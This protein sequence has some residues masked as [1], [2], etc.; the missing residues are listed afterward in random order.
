MTSH[1]LWL[2]L[3][4]LGCYHGIN[5]A[6][7]WLF[8]VALGLQERSASAVLRAVVPLTLGHLLSVAVIVL[9]TVFAVAQF[10]HAIVQRVAA[11]VLLGFGGYRLIR[12]RHPRWV[13]MQVGFWG[14]TAWG[15][16]MSS[17][18]GAGLMLVPFVTARHAGMQGAM[19]MPGAM[20]AAHAPYA[21]GWLVITVHTLGY[22]VAMTTAAFLVYTKFGVSFLRTAWFNVDLVWGAALLAT[23]IV[24]LL[25]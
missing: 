25:T 3:F 8:A 17:A 20:P 10:P 2:A 9:V 23:G 1:Y 18:H 24:L 11:G 22:L 12:A 16:L 4:V 7:G 21:F 5:P 14:L 13:G 6:M 15:F 19:A